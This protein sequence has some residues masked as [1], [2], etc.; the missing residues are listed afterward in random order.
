MTV[1]DRVRVYA[2]DTQIGWNHM[3]GWEILVSN[4]GSSF[5]SP[6]ATNGCQ[7]N[8]SCKSY[9]ENVLTPVP[10]R[11]VRINQTSGTGGPGTY[12]SLAEVEVYGST[13]AVTLPDTNQLR[14]CNYTGR[15]RT[16]QITVG[17]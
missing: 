13:F 4:D 10:A 9:V 17:K 1:I 11:Y 6:I 5:G 12:T 2:G 3:T 16:F 14:L 15:T 8:G 7:Q